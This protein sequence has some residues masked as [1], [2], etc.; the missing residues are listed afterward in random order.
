MSRERFP[1]RFGSYSC[2]AIIDGREIRPI[3]SLTNSVSPQI[4]AELLSQ[5]GY[6]P[7]EVVVDFNILFLDTGRNLVLVDS[8]LGSGYPKMQGRLLSNL[9]EAGF[10]PEDIDLIVLTHGDR[11]HLGGLV[12]AEG[13]PVFP[14]ASYLMSQAAWEWCNAE[15]TLVRLPAEFADFYRKVLPLIKERLRLVD[16]ETEFFPGLTM[17]PAPGHRP[18]HSA[19]RLSLGGKHL[20][21]LAD[22]VGHPLHMLHPEWNWPFDS[23][24]E[25]AAE[26][27]KQLLSW[28]GENQA[29]LFGSHLP[30]PGLGT[31]K[32]H[33]AGWLWEPVKP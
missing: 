25:Q 8:G 32:S 12:N 23:A 20:L 21:H 7:T 28:A 16:A 6:S 9:H 10:K 5:Y 3:S 29:M 17:L 18:G 27:R 1:F 22:A 24:P 19:V 30:Y 15:T 14:Y 4:L 11:D 2:Q 26:T 31:I 13:K 33:E